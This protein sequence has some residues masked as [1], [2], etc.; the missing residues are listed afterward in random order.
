M[1]LYSGVLWNV[2]MVQVRFSS[3]LLR[4]LELPEECVAS[5]RTIREVV[6][7][8]EQRFPGFSAYIV[9]ENG[10]LRQ[11]V[12]IFLG[13]RLLKDRDALSDSL[14]D[15]EEIAIMQALSGG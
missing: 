7:E 5:G 6:D 3:H 13:N 12:N 14:D 10:A 1:M 11:H 9:H 8:L 15:V 2:P 4:H